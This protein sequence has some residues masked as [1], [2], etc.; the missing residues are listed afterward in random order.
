MKLTAVAVCKAHVGAARDDE[1]PPPR[2]MHHRLK[3]QGPARS[4]LERAD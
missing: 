3:Y 4:R 1:L 2:L